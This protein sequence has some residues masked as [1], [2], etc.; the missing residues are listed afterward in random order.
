MRDKIFLKRN[1][2]AIYSFEK[3][4]VLNNITHLHA[5]AMFMFC[6][7]YHLGLRL[8]CNRTLHNFKQEN[9]IYKVAYF[10]H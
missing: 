6:L 5:L 8:I 7:L 2:K 10:K 9:Y 4:N 1:I 3:S